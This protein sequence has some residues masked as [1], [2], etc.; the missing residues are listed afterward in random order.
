MVPRE[1]RACSRKTENPVLPL[2]HDQS[3]EVR[4]AVAHFA[5]QIERAEWR[6]ISARKA[7]QLLRSTLFERVYAVRVRAFAQ[8]YRFTR[9]SLFGD[10][11][12][13]LFSR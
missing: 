2:E 4:N 12:K 7:D 10:R 5:A 9:E 3:D 13:G 6:V 11:L 8:N 1:R